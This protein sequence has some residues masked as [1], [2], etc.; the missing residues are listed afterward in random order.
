MAFVYWIA[1]GGGADVGT[2]TQTMV[3]WIRANGSPALI[4]NGGDVYDDGTPEEFAEFLA[5]FDGSM[6]DVCETAGNH[7]WR[8]KSVS[9]ATGEIPAAYEAFWTKHKPPLSRQPI[10][11][12]RRG[13]AR[14]DHFIDLG[15]W[16]L[17]FVD[18]G[19]CK[20]N[21]WPMGDASRVTWLKDTLAGTPGRAK[22][23]MAHHSRLSRGKHGDVKDVDGLWQTLFGDDGTPRA[24][25]TIGGHDHC[26]SIYESRPRLKPKDGKVPF[27]Q[28]IHVH[29]NGAAGRGHDIGFFGTRPDVFFNDDDYC[30]TRIDLQSPQT[31]VLEVLS[32]GASKNPAAGETPKVLTSFTISV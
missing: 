1:D 23:V 12:S 5:Q 32:F 22:I 27:S 18:T 29:V 24:A 10:E 14:Y 11:T 16:R 19:P 4:V 8:T 13:G 17:V 3:R 6:V 30:I 20:N 31:A 2:V 15:G 28:G 26:V 9:P 25:L 21:P 7:D